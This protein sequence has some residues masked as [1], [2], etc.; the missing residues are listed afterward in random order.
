MITKNSLDIFSKCLIKYIHKI[1]EDYKGGFIRCTFIS[2]ATLEIDDE[3]FI[4]T[5]RDGEYMRGKYTQ[6]LRVALEVQDEDVFI[7]VH[8]YVED[9]YYEN[10][11]N[12]MIYERY[13]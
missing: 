4:L 1:S 13:P 5:T 9:D 6:L 12:A 2:G 11:F 7:T 10:V 8:K 3:M